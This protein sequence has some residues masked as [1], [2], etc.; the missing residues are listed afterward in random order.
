MRRMVEMMT[1]DE[2]ER[3]FGKLIASLKSQI[4][5]RVEC[6]ANDALSREEA[7]QLVAMINDRLVDVGGREPWECSFY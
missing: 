7:L 5:D 2:L 1:A 6:D 4:W 3:E